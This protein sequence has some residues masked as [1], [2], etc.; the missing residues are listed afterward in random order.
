MHSH[1]RIACVPFSVPWL[2][3]VAHKVIH[4]DSPDLEPD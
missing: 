1:F 4:Q 2:F 3:A